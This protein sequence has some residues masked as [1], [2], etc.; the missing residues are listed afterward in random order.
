MGVRIP[1]PWEL[2]DFRVNHLDATQAEAGKMFQ[3]SQAT[4]ARWEMPREE[5]G[6]PVHPFLV[7]SVV[8]GITKR[9]YKLPAKRSAKQRWQKHIG[10]KKER[11]LAR[12]SG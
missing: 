4:W 6:H 8:D 5:G 12:A 2:W 1:K 11:K 9:G 10:A 7:S 3:V